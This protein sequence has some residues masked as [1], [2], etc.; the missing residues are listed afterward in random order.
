MKIKTKR[1]FAAVL[2][3]LMI[4][5]NAGITAFA[6]TDSETDSV[7]END[8]SSVA[9][10]SSEEETEEASEGA[11]ITL[12]DLAKYYAN[13]TLKLNYSDEDD[14][15]IDY[16]GDDYYDTDGNATLINNQQI[17]YNSDEM[18]FISVTTKDGNV[19]YIL[20]NYSDNDNIDN[21]YFLNKVDSFDLY[22]LLYTSDDSST[23]DPE[24][25]EAAAEQATGGNTKKSS[26]NSTDGETAVT[27]LESSAETATTNSATSGMAKELMILGVCAVVAVLIFF[28]MLNMKKKNKNKVQSANEEFSFD[29]EDDDI[30]EDEE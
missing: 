12:E 30:N 25:V 6:D 10:N 4:A 11:E 19:F 28:V 8:T 24:A 22:S 3:S 2:A 1:A 18:Q 15:S 27:D 23:I 17:I 29:D 20:I 7:A 21:V 14:S 9:D 26:S 5:L 16:Y 13:G